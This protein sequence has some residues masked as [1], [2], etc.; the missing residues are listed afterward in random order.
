MR[1]LLHRVRQAEL[2]H[3]ALLQLVRMHLRALPPG[4]RAE[5][6]R[7]S[8]ISPSR[9]SHII[10]GRNVRTVVLSRLLPHLEDILAEVS[11]GTFVIY[12]P[13][14]PRVAASR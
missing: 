8:R 6:A 11:A 9:L 1:A 5:L 14:A 4:G 2:D 7:R 13:K 12:D 3:Q 10:G